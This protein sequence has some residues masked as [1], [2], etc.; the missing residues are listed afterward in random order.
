MRLVP[1]CFLCNVGT[2]NKQEPHD[3]QKY[4]AW[5]Q[6]QHPKPAHAQRSYNRSP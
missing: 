6:S 5:N 2:Q 1:E 3:P 4:T